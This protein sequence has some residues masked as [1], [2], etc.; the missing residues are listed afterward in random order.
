MLTIVVIRWIGVPFSW[1][2]ALVLLG[3][4]SLTAM[5]ERPSRAE[6]IALGLAGAA[7]FSLA[8]GLSIEPGTVNAWLTSLG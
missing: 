8:I 6:W 3:L 7:Q 1:Q 5:P 2:E 4:L